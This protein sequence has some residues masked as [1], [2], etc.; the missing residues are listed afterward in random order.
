MD[1]KAAEEFYLRTWAETTVEVNGIEG[2]SPVLQ[3]TVLPAFAQANVSVRLAP[4]QDPEQIAPVFERLVREAAPEGADVSVELWSW[5]EAGLVPPDA[6]AIRLG[7]DAFEKVL[8]VRPL[9]IRS[10]GSLPIVPALAKKNVATIITGF[11]LPESNVHSPN[12]R[13][14]VEYVPKGIETARGLFTE[15][16]K[17]RAS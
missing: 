4:G 3:K 9:L 7:Q 11:A 8:G 15:L 6:P 2:G 1:A 12:E 17:L 5:S 14:L 13:L 16:A 10:G